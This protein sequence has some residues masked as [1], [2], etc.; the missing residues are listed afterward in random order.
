MAEIEKINSSTSLKDFPDTYNKNNNE[1]VELINSLQKEI[2]ALKASHNED[3]KKLQS[4]FETWKTNHTNEFN[5]KLD[6]FEKSFV[7]KE[8]FE[9]DV[10]TIIDANK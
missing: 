7:T 9:K 3:V 6:E 4:A 8:T 2:N 1:L 5:T 10:K